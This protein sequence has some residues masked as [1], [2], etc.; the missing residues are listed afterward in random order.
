MAVQRLVIYKSC[1]PLVQSLHLSDGGELCDGMRD[2]EPVDI[3]IV[4]GCR[5]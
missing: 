3:Q 2:G 1:I 5:F 4:E